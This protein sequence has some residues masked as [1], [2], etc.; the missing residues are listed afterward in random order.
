MLLL[1]KT[2]E[3]NHKPVHEY[4]FGPN[5]SLQDKIDIDGLATIIASEVESDIIEQ[6]QQ[7]QG[8]SKSNLDKM[9]E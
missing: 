6:Q 8:T 9:F 3:K 7:E 5:I 4:M 1:Q 2:A